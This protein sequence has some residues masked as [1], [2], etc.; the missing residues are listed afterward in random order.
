MMTL[1]YSNFAPSADHVG[2]LETLVGAGRVT[3]AD[4]EASALI[5]APSTQIVFG[6]RYLRQLLPHAPDVRWVQTTAGGFDQLP[7]QE[8]AARGIT[9]SRNPLNSEAIAHHAVALAWALLRRVPAAVQ[10]QTERRWAAP[11]AM[12][13]LPRTA[14]VLGLGAIG[15]QIARLL[16]GLGLHVRGTANSGTNAQR[17]TCNEFI[18]ANGWRDVLPDTDIVVLA[19]PLDETTRG[20][21]GTRELAALPRHALV[22]S[23]AR[24]AVIDRP[25]LLDAL[26]N[27]RLGGAALDVLDP[28]P[29]SDDALWT[30]PGLLITPKVSAYH[31]DMQKKFEA[32]AEAQLRRYLAGA[33]LEA[34]VALDRPESA[35]M[36]SSLSRSVR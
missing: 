19:L 14:L 15:T 27:G 18:E 7:C 24:D 13:P 21:I 26:R 5:H 20:C 29:A 8:L 9:L 35:L 36:R 22:V 31:P 10:A 12:L 3:V 25:A 30:T 11:F 23:I 2:H 34:V 17:E 33:P 1:M 16:R 6:H 4:S 28:V 32:F